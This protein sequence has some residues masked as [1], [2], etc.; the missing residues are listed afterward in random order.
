MTQIWHTDMCHVLWKMAL[1]RKRI[2]SFFLLLFCFFL[3]CISS[4]DQFIR[5]QTFHFHSGHVSSLVDKN[6]P[7]GLALCFHCHNCIEQNSSATRMKQHFHRVLFIFII[8]KTSMLSQWAWHICFNTMLSKWLNQWTIFTQVLRKQLILTSKFFEEKEILQWLKFILRSDDSSLGHH[9]HQKHQW[10]KT[11]KECQT[12]KLHEF[13]Q[14]KFWSNNNFCVF[15]CLLTT[16]QHQGVKPHL[17]DHWNEHK[18]NFLASSSFLQHQHCIGTHVELLCVHVKKQE[19]I[20]NWIIGQRTNC[21]TCKLLKQLTCSF[22][23]MNSNPCAESKAT[24]WH[25]KLTKLCMHV[26][27]IEVR[28]CSCCVSLSSTSTKCLFVMLQCHWCQNHR[29]TWLP[30]DAKIWFV[31]FFI[32]FWRHQNL[33]RVGCC[34]QQQTLF[35]QKLSSLTNMMF[36]FPTEDEWTLCFNERNGE[37]QQKQNQTHNACGSMQHIKIGF[38]FR[39]NHDKKVNFISSLLKVS[40]PFTVVSSGWRCLPQGIK[41]SFATAVLS[42]FDCN[43]WSK[44]GGE[45]GLS[46][47]KV[48]AGREWIVQKCNLQFAGSW[49]ASKMKCERTGDDIRLA[50]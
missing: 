48:L 9:T 32:G 50:F 8:P 40:M 17:K 36:E 26:C 25:T 3:L 20:E 45:S 31:L 5:G 19:E 42:R 49:A 11:S 23:P 33:Q 22:W 6:V 41:V 13:S 29:S 37:K 30:K 1:K 16:G 12:R 38:I 47:E 14:Q 39:N 10:V 46:F 34:L 24:E 4:L 27:Q 43:F 18:L 35:L 7:D 15:C 44:W 21:L 28:N 2:V